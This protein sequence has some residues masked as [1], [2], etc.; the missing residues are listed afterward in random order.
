MRKLFGI[1][2]LLSFFLAQS[3]F[4]SV[5]IQASLDRNT[6]TLEDEIELTITISGELSTAEP[7]LPSM[8]AFHIVASGSSSN[9]QMI[10]GILSVQKEYSYLLIPQAEGKNILSVLKECH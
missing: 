3:S 5:G 1:T 9:I 4:A 8:P 7:N 2:F 6:G 10:N